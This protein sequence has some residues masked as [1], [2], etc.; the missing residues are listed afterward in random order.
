LRVA[1][2][3]PGCS[4]GCHVT[5]HASAETVRPVL[6]C[7]LIPSPCTF[8]TS[9]CQEAATDKSCCC[10]REFIVGRDEFSANSGPNTACHISAFVERK[11]SSSV[12]L[13][14]F[15]RA[16]LLSLFQSCQYAFKIIHRTN[17]TLSLNTQRKKESGGT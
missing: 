14:S 3:M 8:P 7:D 2:D 4:L 15:L 10:P 16:S 9:T 6:Q 12:S 17:T 11:N 1:C 13:L 5:S